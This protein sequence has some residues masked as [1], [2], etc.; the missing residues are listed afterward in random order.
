MGE[1]QFPVIAGWPNQ[2]G[3]GS[4]WTDSLGSCTACHTRHAFSIEMGEKTGHLQ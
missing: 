2:G 4:I 3:E 1:M